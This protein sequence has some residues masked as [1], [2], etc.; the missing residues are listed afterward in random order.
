MRELNRAFWLEEHYP[1]TIVRDRYSGLF[2]GGKYVAFPSSFDELDPAIG[3]D[4][5]DCAA[6]WAE[7][8]QS[9]YGVGETPQEAV[10]H[11]KEKLAQAA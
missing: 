5:G 2:S 6:Y 7:A 3:G 9:P 11:L 1:T 10:Q 8:D 4:D